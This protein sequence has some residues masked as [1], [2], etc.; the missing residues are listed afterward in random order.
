MAAQRDDRRCIDGKE[1]LS[2]DNLCA[3]MW[4]SG[5]ETSLLLGGDVAANEGGDVAANEGGETVPVVLAS[6]G[7]NKTTVFMRT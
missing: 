4:Q 3:H 5:N 2:T 1:S 7:S 6:G